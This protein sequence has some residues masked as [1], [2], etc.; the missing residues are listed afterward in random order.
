MPDNQTLSDTITEHC[1][2][3][4]L[5]ALAAERHPL[6]KLNCPEL[7]DLNFICLGVL[8]CLS[9]VDSGHHFLQTAEDI[10]Q[11]QIPLS[12]Y[13]NSLKSSRRTTM[14]KAVEQQSYQLHSDTLQ[15][16]GIDYLSHFPELNDYTV[17]AA[18][19]HFI[20]HACHTE[21]SPNGVVYAAGFIYAFNLRNG[22]I[23]PLCTVTNGTRRSQEIPK[24]RAHIEK[25]NRTQRQGQKRLYV[26]D[27]AVTDYA[28]WDRQKRHNTTMI[29]LLKEN[30]SAKRV[31]AI[32]FDGDGQINIGI[33][34]Y[35]TYENDRGIR[36]SVVTYRDPETKHCY[37]FITT[38]PESMKPGIIALLYYKRWTIEK[39]F[40]N[41]KSNLKETKAWS[42]DPH[43]LRNQMRFTAMGYNL[44]RVF[45]EL[46]KR[47]D[48]ELVHRADKKYTKALEKRQ[49]V[50][51]KQGR[52]VNRLLFQPRIARISSYTIRAAQNAIT[53]GKTRVALMSQLAARLVPRV[54]LMVEH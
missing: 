21:K 42:P 46:S 18:D 5:N 31:D 27:K 33:E 30:S 16:H 44:M 40:N 3:S 50:A 37:R 52:F 17:E 2:Q 12:T 29:S 24:L 8:R 47:Q 38:L 11:Q 51:K 9:T 22:L 28:W 41:S 39:A 13:F 19:G 20:D 49:Q 26:Y 36:F 10:H 34:G 32:P 53:K 4:L 48:P 1:N 54:T 43:A 35:D 14:L 25:N 6:W 15:R 23:S 45:E 7:T